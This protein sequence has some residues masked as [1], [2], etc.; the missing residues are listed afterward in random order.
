MWHYHTEFLM[1]GYGAYVVFFEFLKKAFPEI[2]DQA[3]A[4]MVAGI[5]ILMY[6]PDEEL[7]RLAKLAVESDLD[8][9]FSDGTDP[10]AAFAALRDRGKAGEK[11]LAEYRKSADPWFLVS[12]GD[13]FYHHH[14]SW[15]DNPAVPFA[16]M[17]RYVTKIRAGES[18]ERPT[19]KL[20]TERDRV[21]CAPRQRGR[22]RGIRPDARALPARVPICRRPQVLL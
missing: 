19:A 5:D 17:S 3:V 4:R 21:P 2:P 13:G 8:D 11:W 20:L 9:I 7:K 6:R 22:A 16:A 10:S 18:L 15:Q 14:R 12:T 1:L